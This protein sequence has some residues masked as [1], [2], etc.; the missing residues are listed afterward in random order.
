MK[1]HYCK[2]PLGNFG[3]DLNTWLWPTLLGDSFFNTHEDCLFL[4]VGT[5]LNQK[6]PKRAEKIVLGTGT[7]YQRPP[8]VDGKFSIYSVRGPLTAKALNIPLRKSIGD[9]AYLCLATDRFKK[10]LALPKKYRVS[11]IPHHQTA[12]TIDWET[13]GNVGELHF[14][15]PRKEFFQVFEDIAQSEC[16]LTES[17][18]GAIFADALRTAW[19]PFRMGHRFNMFKW[20][21]WLESIHI[22]LPAFQKYPI[23]CS[24]KLSLPRRAKHVIERVCGNTLRYDRLSQKP[25][26][27][28]SAHE[29]EEFAKQLERQSQTKPF[30]LSKDIT[31]QNILNGLNDCVESI[32]A[33][34]GNEL[35][36]IA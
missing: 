28:N 14:I 25:I 18:H 31:L 8:K 9:S 32:R 5:I 3:D 22:E 4:G 7:G 26:R 2:T 34:Y 23:L 13:I 19:Q 24:E 29:L 35:R 11:V 16:V 6:L 30:Y 17:L 27:T 15:D 12:T 1:L 20:R 10:L 21:D 36:S 33:Q